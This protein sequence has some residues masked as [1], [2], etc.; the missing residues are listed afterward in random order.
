MSAVMTGPLVSAVIPTRNRPEMVVRAVSS[1][2]SQT[3][4]NIEVVV[5]VDGPDR[6]TADALERVN[7]PRLKIVLLPESVGGSGARNA[8][9]KAANGEWVAFLDDDDVWLPE[10]IQKQLALAISA[11]EPYPVIACRLIAQTNNEQFI[12]PKRLPMPHEAIGDYLFYRKSFFQGE[13]LIQTSTLFL[14]KELILKVPFKKLR[15]HQDWDWLL[16]ASETTGFRLIFEAEPQAVW[17]IDENRSRVSTKYSSDEWKD[18]LKWIS[19]HH[20]KISNRSYTNFLMTV[21]AD[22][23]SRAGDTPAIKKILSEVIKNGGPNFWA[24]GSF[25]AIWL[26][27]KHIRHKMRSF[28]SNI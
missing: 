18:S 23:A 24:A 6:G 10:K 19:S 21:V 17:F 22:M 8:G 4:E 14:P 13:T 9:V 26:F 16:R 12:W 5:V 20:E 1:A 7:N 2:L 28:F 3:Y 11:P 27:P 15:R 25:L